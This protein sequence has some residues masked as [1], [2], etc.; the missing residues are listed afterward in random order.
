VET[1]ER[2][3]DHGRELEAFTDTLAMDLVRQV[4]ETDE[5]HWFLL[6]GDRLSGRAV[7]RRRGGAIPF[8]RR[9]GA[10]ILVGVIRHG[11]C[12][13]L[14]TMK[15][16]VRGSGGGR[17][18]GKRATR[19]VV[20]DP[21]STVVASGLPPRRYGRAHPFYASHALVRSPLYNF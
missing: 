15:A 19:P 7:L 18:K 17:P 21:E 8:I 3:N 1:R 12:M 4:G 6:D 10:A 5:A 16:S 14:E 20:T 11:D 9:V 2:T 13:K